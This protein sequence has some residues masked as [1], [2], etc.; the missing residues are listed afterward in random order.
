MQPSLRNNKYLA[1]DGHYLIRDEPS[2]F[3]NYFDWIVTETTVIKNKEIPN[4]IFVKTDYLR[5]FSNTL[6]HTLR[7][8]FIVITG[9]SDYSPPI[10]F[11][12]EYDN[13]ISHPLLIK[14]YMTN[15]LVDHDKV[16]SYP[17]GLCHNETSDSILF[18]LRNSLV[19]HD[20]NKILCIW[21]NRIFNVCGDEYITRDKVLHFVK[22]YPDIF[23]VVAPNFEN[24][25]F[26]KLLSK[27]KFVL[28][29]VGNG[30][31]PCPKS[32]E[33]IILKT[34]PIL[35]NTLNTKPVYSELPAIVVDDFKEVLEMNLDEIYESY[36]PSLND[37]ET[38]YKLTCKYWYDRIM[39]DLHEYP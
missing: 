3:S 16:V 13:I 10:N 22:Q 11:K 26:Y 32:F 34:I 12:N 6:L 29:P 14:W 8:K 27:Y 4:T 24:N 19:K 9:A 35:I 38:H 39:N 20:S 31:D 37:E 36:K 21:R 17:G 1:D 33:A 7:E 18:E 5:I 23:D 2:R 15:C 25:E 28:C 30:V